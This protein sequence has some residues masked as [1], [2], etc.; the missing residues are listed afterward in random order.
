MCF[1]QNSLS[2]VSWFWPLIIQYW[3]QFLKI[4]LHADVGMQYLN[5]LDMDKQAAKLR[6]PHPKQRWAIRSDV[7]VKLFVRVCVCVRT[8]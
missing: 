3:L 1:Y 2:S 8:L 6:M 5:P 4:Q 7:A